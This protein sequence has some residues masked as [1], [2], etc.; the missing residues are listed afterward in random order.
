[1]SPSSRTTSLSVRMPNDLHAWLK[2]EAK[3]LGKPM[4]WVVIE[5]LSHVCML[6]VEYHLRKQT[7]GR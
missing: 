5:A 2:A 1:V 6:D 3:R 4:S 7:R